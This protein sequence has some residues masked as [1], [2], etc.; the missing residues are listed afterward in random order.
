[1]GSN[2][3][4]SIGNAKIITMGI[5]T[6]KIVS[7]LTNGIVHTS[8]NGYESVVVGSCSWSSVMGAPVVYSS[9]EII[10]GVVVVKYLFVGVLCIG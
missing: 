2:I 7:I 1:M 4:T 5:V 6:D 9:L 8:G 3:V 10:V